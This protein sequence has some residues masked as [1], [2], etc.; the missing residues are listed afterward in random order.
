M[1]LFGPKKTAQEKY[2]EKEAKQLKKKY[3]KEIT[4]FENENSGVNGEHLRRAVNEILEKCRP[5]E[6]K[7]GRPHSLDREIDEIVWRLQESFGEKACLYAYVL[8]AEQMPNYAPFFQDLILD[9]RRREQQ[10]QGSFKLEFST[11]VIADQMIPVCEKAIA[12]TGWEG[13]V[14]R[15]T[16]N[17]FVKSRTLISAEDFCPERVKEED[18]LFHRICRACAAASPDIS[19]T[20]SCEFEDRETGKSVSISVRYEEETLTFREKE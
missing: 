14:I 13:K 11:R 3:A 16:T 15:Y 9:C 12:G 8:F 1:G 2:N 5:Y 7:A 4:A 6:N 20:G 10:S 18:T 19:F 17:T